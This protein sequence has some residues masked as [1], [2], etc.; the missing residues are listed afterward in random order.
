MSQKFLSSASHCA[1][2]GYMLHVIFKQT[3]TNKVG[4]CC[5]HVGDGVE[6][7]KTTPN[8]RQQHAAGCTNAPNM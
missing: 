6:M 3:D 8:K 4:S 7:D 2:I 1:S 5:V